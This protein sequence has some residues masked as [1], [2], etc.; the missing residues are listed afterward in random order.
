MKEESLKKLKILAIKIAEEKLELQ[1]G[2]ET[3]KPINQDRVN[4]SQISDITSQTALKKLELRNKIEKL[5]KEYKKEY[6]KIKKFI[7]QIKE[8]HLQKY[9]ELKYL[10]FY[11]EYKIEKT[12]NK[13]KRTMQRYRK[14][15]KEKYLKV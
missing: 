4:S 8:P 3:N 10:K 1:E 5:E 15:F 14:E 11:T 12:L 2:I 7:S 9:A 13:T 6:K